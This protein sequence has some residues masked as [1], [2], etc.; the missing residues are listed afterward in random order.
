MGSAAEKKR[1]NS[2][3]SVVNTR[4]RIA[5][6][7]LEKHATPFRQISRSFQSE[8]GITLYSLCEIWHTLRSKNRSV[9][10]MICSFAETITNKNALIKKLSNTIHL[11]R[12]RLALLEKL[13]AAKTTTAAPRDSADDAE[14]GRVKLSG[15]QDHADGA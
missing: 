14:A 7:W 5:E 1:L 2:G 15:V 3:M 13:T 4:K 8:H 6:I 9:E 12:E 11:Q 10:L